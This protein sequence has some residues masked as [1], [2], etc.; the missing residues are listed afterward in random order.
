M[1]GPFAVL[2]TFLGIPIGFWA[3]K[4]RRSILAMALFL[5]SLMTTLTGSVAS[6][7]QRC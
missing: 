3:D 4:E 1:V 2:Y 7:G 5:W 6:V